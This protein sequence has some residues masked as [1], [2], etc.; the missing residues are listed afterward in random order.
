MTRGI[1]LL[2]AFPVVMTAGCDSGSEPSGA[3]Y[4]LETVTA[5]PAQSLPGDSL[6]AI[7]V[8]VVSRSGLPLTNVSV[9]WTGDGS[10][11]PATSVTDQDGIA[12]TTWVLPQ[13]DGGF[14]HTSGPP[15]DYQLTASTGDASVTLETSA[16]A[17]KVDKVNASGYAAC[18]L[19]SQTLWCWGVDL[20]WIVAMPDTWNYAVPREFPDVGPVTD[21]ALGLYA[22]CVRS[23]AGEI[24]CSSTRT[25][26]QFLAITDAPAL[27][28]LTGG[29]DYFCG[30]AGDGTAWCWH[31]DDGAAAVLQAIQI[32]STLQ[33]VQVG[34]GGHANG[35]DS[36][37]CGLTQEGAA[38]CWGSNGDGE[39]GN[40]TTNPSVVPLAVT[41]GHVFKQL[42]VST[43]AA[44][45][46]D[47]N[48]AIWCW[49]WEGLPPV[50]SSVPVETGVTGPIFALG[51]FNGY[52]SSPAIRSWYLGTAIDRPD[53][54]A[55]HVQAL[56]EKGQLC[57]LTPGNEVYCSWVML[58]GASESTV[59]P[60]ALVPVPRPDVPSSTARISQGSRRS[61]TAA[62]PTSFP[63]TR[64][65]V[66]H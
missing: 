13:L 31:A 21:V 66:P 24:R 25:N 7:T 12:T 39:L 29:G 19:R 6:K 56:S 28:H 59:H 47:Q 48:D 54:N 14:F 45:G 61:A 55:L 18:G 60:S 44:C 11:V 40:G 3:A 17:F 16:H 26:L 1:I 9:T 10:A 4:T 52:T 8:R 27:D 37:A 46:V 34:A 65:P 23:P 51:A 2:V 32:S 63:A 53:L 58:D 50:P 62:T 49:G 20:P 22:G 15:G 36:F 43:D 5:P 42:A 35:F 30:I 41:G 64:H 38:Y 57:A 33:F